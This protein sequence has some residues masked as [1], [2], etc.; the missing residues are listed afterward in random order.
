MYAAAER[1]W[2]LRLLF[3]SVC[4]SGQ[5]GHCEIECDGT[6]LYVLLQISRRCYLGGVTLRW[7]ALKLERCV[8]FGFRMVRG[9]GKSDSE[10]VRVL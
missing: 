9:K 4:E 5:K 3:V 2:L 1:A 10:Q 6:V 7:V 8:C